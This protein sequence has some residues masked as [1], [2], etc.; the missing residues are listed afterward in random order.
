M[1]HR[2]KFHP[3]LFETHCAISGAE[4]VPLRPCYSFGSNFEKAGQDIRET[5][6]VF[7][8]CKN[9]GSWPCSFLRYVRLWY[10]VMFFLS[11]HTVVWQPLLSWYYGLRFAVLPILTQSRQSALWQHSSCMGLVL[12][13]LRGGSGGTGH[14]Q[15]ML[16]GRYSNVLWA[17]FDGGVAVCM[18]G[19]LHT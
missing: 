5:K 4:N 14:A 17:M 9:D 2:A 12:T 6:Y 1:L 8:V 15:H 19:N 13:S 7:A 10:F 16:P 18:D 11:P 3:I